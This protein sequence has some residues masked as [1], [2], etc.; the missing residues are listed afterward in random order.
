MPAYNEEDN[1]RNVIEQWYPI[2]EGKSEESRLVI[3]DAGSKD[4]THDI[5]LEMK[6]E[7]PKLEVLTTSNQYHG[8]KVIALYNYAKSR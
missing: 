1:V 4:K 3:A 6:K 2:L 7:Y 5:L 8:P